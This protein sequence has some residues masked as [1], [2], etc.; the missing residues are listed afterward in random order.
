MQTLRGTNTKAARVFFSLFCFKFEF[1]FLQ[2]QKFVGCQ[3]YCYRDEKQV[4]VTLS[5]LVSIS[6][7]CVANS[8]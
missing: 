1:K 7:S 4:C 6:A 2:T 5:Y 8:W 3:D